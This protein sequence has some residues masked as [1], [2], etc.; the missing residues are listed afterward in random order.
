M[1]SKNL[2][3]GSKGDTL[4]KVIFILLQNNNINNLVLQ[5]IMKNE[6]HLF[7]SVASHLAVLHESLSELKQDYLNYR[8]KYLNDTTD[9]FEQ[10]EKKKSKP[11]FLSFEPG[12]LYLLFHI[13][14]DY[15]SCTFWCGFKYK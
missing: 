4:H 5:D 15:F 10:A 3:Q 12:M 13:V 8:S 14:N 6:Y 2:F 7:V 1:K 9:I 11:K